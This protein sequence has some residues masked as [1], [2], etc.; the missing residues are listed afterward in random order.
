MQEYRLDKVSKEPLALQLD[1][2]HTAGLNAQIKFFAEI[3]GFF[4]AV[5]HIVI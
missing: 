2:V 5:A 3:W 4:C 1:L